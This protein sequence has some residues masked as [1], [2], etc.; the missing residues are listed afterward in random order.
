VGRRGVRTRALRVY[1]EAFAAKR[2]STRRLYF[3]VSAAALVATT[4]ELAQTIAER[5]RQIGLDRMFYGSDG[6]FGNHPDPKDSWAAFRKNM[7]LTPA[8]ID[9][10]AKNVAPYLRQQASE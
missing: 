8:E 7:A 5:M 9:R 4:P 2:P 1:A 10:I 3:D 6:A